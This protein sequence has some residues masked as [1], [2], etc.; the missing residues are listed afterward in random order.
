MGKCFMTGPVFLVLRKFIE[1]LPV[2]F[3]LF[4]GETKMAE[5]EWV[6]L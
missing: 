1:K 6:K 4:K 3:I 2:E 5:Y